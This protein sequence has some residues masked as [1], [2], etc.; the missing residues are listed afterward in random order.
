MKTTI[1][2]V[3][4][5]G[6][7]LTFMLLA[8]N[9]HAQDTDLLNKKFKNWERKERSKMPS[10]R[11]KL[12]FDVQ[13]SAVAME[14]F[15]SS[16]REVFYRNNLSNEEFSVTER[17]FSFSMFNVTFAPR[18][19]FYQD[20]NKAFGLKTVVGVSISAYENSAP[21][22]KAGFLGVN[23][24][25]FGYFARGLCGPYNNISN[26]GLLLGLGVTGIRTP[27]IIAE[28]SNFFNSNEVTANSIKPNKNNWLLPSIS[29]DMYNKFGYSS[30][31]INY[32]L[33][34]GYWGG[35]TYYKM[36]LGLA[37]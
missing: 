11:K 23:Y 30:K 15:I 16:Q 25:A 24:G 9:I 29:I 36:S 20:E 13:F 32:N 31:I 3:L 27:L 26:K 22:S 19:N 21:Y 10:I 6:L 8:T 37:F 34:L 35:S 33:T 28:E 5:A 17:A 2:N 14:M 18:Y 1:I 12:S 4:S 7:I